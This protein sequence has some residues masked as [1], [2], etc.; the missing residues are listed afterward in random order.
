MDTASF[1]DIIET[2]RVSAGDSKPF[3]EALA[4]SLATGVEQEILDYQEQ[5]DEALWALVMPSG[6]TSETA[7]TA[8]RCAPHDDPG[9]EDQAIAA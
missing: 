6:P 8:D 5:F 2:A 4:D 7:V 9:L 3:H 1:W